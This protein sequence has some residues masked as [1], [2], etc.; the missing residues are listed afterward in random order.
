[1]EKIN[2]IMDDRKINIDLIRIVSIIGVILIHTTTYVAEGCFW[3]VPCFVVISGALWLNRPDVSIKKILTKNVARLLSLLWGC[4]FLYAIVNEGIIHFLDNQSIN[5]HDFWVM[6]V[7][8]RYHFW[9]IW[10]IVGL[11]LITPLLNRGMQDTRVAYYFLIVLFLFSIVVPSLQNLHFLEW[12]KWITGKMSLQFSQYLFYFV[13]GGCLYRIKIDGKPIIK[14]VIYILGIVIFAVR[15]MEITPFLNDVF[16]VLCVVCIWGLAKEIGKR[17]GGVC[18]KV[19]IGVSD[20][21][22]G[23]F[24]VHDFFITIFNRATVDMAIGENVVVSMVEPVFVVFSSFIFCYAIT[25]LS[26]VRRFLC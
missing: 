25:R 24:L 14:V 21:S 9:F 13:L 4:S 16:E 6:V 7:E 12:T 26:I 19:V 3:A 5:W 17:I 23:V 1:M 20:L 11:Y 8:G 10:M 2:N 18:R 15:I 22:L